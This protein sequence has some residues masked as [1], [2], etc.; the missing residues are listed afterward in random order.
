MS[1]LNKKQEELD[2]LLKDAPTEKIIEFFRT[3]DTV[4]ELAVNVI[5]WGHNFL[6][7]YF[8]APTPEF[9]YGLVKKF[10]NNRNEYNAY[11]RGFGK[12]TV[13]QLCIAFSIAH[14]LD[15]FIVLLEKSYDEAS[16]V[17]EA[18]REEFKHNDNILNVYGDLT[19]ISSTGKKEEKLKDS[20]G[21]FFING[22]RLRARGFDKNVRGLKSR[23][24]R[25]SKIIGDDVESDEH[26]ENP[27]Q[28]RKY[29]NN[30]LRGVVPA[31]SNEMG[32]VKFFGTIL[33]DDSLLQTL[34]NNHGGDTYRAWD[35]NRNLLWKD[36][37]TVEKLEEKRKEMSIEGR[38]D[39]AFYQEY[40]NE[41]VSEEDQIFKKEFFK[42]Y[43]DKQLEEEIMAKPHRAYVLVDPAI[44]K[45]DSADFTAI[46][47]VV[48]DRMHRL[49]VAEIVRERLDPQETL[50]H[51]IAMYER[52]QPVKVGIESVAYQKALVWYI[53]D[54]KRLLPSI[55]S[56]QVQ[57][58]KAD[59]DKER[60]IRQI[61]P[62]Y[63]DGNV[64]HNEND[65][66]TKVLESELLRFP[67]GATDD[68]I[69]ALSNIEQIMLPARRVTQDTY[70]KYLKRSAHG[71][72][73]Y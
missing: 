63:A 23:Q 47:A 16:E 61:Q 62:R 12:T 69:D 30:Y 14:G 38:G 37:W 42:Y 56:M 35:E 71:Q 67:R 39:A 54:K 24:Y 15:T 68:V 2:K 49:F 41:P 4:D 36:F 18:V 64:Y 72:V 13:I 6:P 48:V 5:L 31:T 59:M 25:P 22:I 55:R 19:K 44:S 53:E 1:L 52:W 33:H 8:F 9:H 46:V 45:R 26:I 34:I 60:K 17:L 28:R 27:E 3:F 20:V 7:D 57:E 29:L 32:N 73:A 40:F 11:P 21:D 66:A 70:K 51:L 43:N 50:K 65:H 58:V 10:F